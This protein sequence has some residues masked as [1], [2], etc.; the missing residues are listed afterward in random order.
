MMP[1]R[2]RRRLRSA[3]LRGFALGCGLVWAAVA[4]GWS[5]HGI[6]TAAALAG[7]DEL[8]QLAPARVES[9]QTFLEAQ[10]EALVR[11]LDEEER[12]ARAQV[13][14]YPPRPPALRFVTGAGADGTELRR[15]F[16][17]AVRVPP[18]M[19]LGL[20]LRREPG[21]PGTS[22]DG[23]EPLA[24]SEAT[25]LPDDATLAPATFAALRDG[26]AIAPLAV[27]ASAADEPDYGLDIGLWED[28]GTAWGREYG[29]GDQPFGNPALEF[30]SQAPFHMGF[31]HESRIVYA[32]AGFL[33]RTLPEY[34]IHLW[35]TLA[36]H[37]LAT[38]H[39]YWGWR[40]AG[41]AVHYLQDLTQPYHAR[42]LPDVS[43]ARM[44]WINTLYTLGLP[45][46]RDQAVTL[47]SNRHLALENFQR[48]AL[49]AAAGGDDPAVALLDALASAASGDEPRYDDAMARAQVSL[50]AAGAA[51]RVDRVV[52]AHLPAAYVRDPGFDFGA[53]AEG[54]DLYALVGQADPDDRDALLQALGP[55]LADLGV[56]TRAVVR[57]LLP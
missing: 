12:W 47:V 22:A 43:T 11:V 9:L 15:R 44:L 56:F 16:L 49:L 55:L 7:M 39:D 14:L 30:G 5:G 57:T 50:R 10:G 51:D 52:G 48:H 53:A 6:A 19:P 18:G 29:F 1:A 31:W 33:R 36:R 21:L 37:A 2:R 34:R 3:T 8:A 42:V 25:I 26:D 40:F 23:D 46:A 20:F 24:V 28:N 38:G 27:L 32:A 45:R 54:V 41:W 13:P 35:L 17:A 4:F